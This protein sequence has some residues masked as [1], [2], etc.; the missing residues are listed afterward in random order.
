MY[1]IEGVLTQPRLGLS[2]ASYKQLL[3]ADL[4]IHAG[5]PM[6]I[7]LSLSE[8]EQS[9]LYPAKSLVQLA[10]DIH[11]A[12]GLNHFIHVVGFMSP[13][14]EHNALSD[15]DHLLDNQPP[16]EKMKFLADSYI[17]KSLHS[18][19]IPLST[20]N[21]SVIVGDSFSG[22]TEQ[23]GGLS[24]LVDA[25]RRKLMPLVPGGDDYWLPMVHI[26]HVA[27]FISKLV[28]TEGLTSNTYY[29]LDAKQE[30]PSIRAFIQLM[31]RELQTAQPL[32]KAKV[33]LPL[34][35]TLLGMGAGKVLGIPKESM[36]FLVKSEFPVDSKLEIEQKNGMKSSVVPSTLPFIISDLDY[37][38][39]HLGQNQNGTDDFYQRR[40]A[41][42]I[43]LEKD[44]DEPP[45]IFLHGTFSSADTLLPI[46]RFLSDLNTWFVDLPGFGRTP[47]HHN[48]S[49][50]EGY[51]ESVIAMIAELN[52]PVLLVGHSFGGL[53]AAQVMERLPPMIKQLILM[54]PVL[55]PIQPKYKFR[56]ATSFILK[57]MKP[58]LLEKELLQTKSFLSSS[59]L[60]KDYARSVTRDLKSPRIRKTNAAVM[61]YLTQSKSIQ[62]N[63][64]AWD[65]SKVKILW[66]TLDKDHYIP[67]QFEHL[68]ITNI[69]YGHQFPVESPEL[70][71]EWISGVVRV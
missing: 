53:I 19:G 65:K 59:P 37:R 30:S 10:K 52:R 69:E 46:S 32:G 23:L 36:S 6:N 67:K 48:P 3:A 43:L 18:V 39:N 16:Y 38:L 35:K 31:A 49:V 8:A 22:K 34:L 44:S 21:P 14:H 7:E 24:I 57:Y 63:P 60:L 61:S 11:A 4:I 29:M 26:D 42:L 70:T 64:V 9:F 5:G 12:K 25:V 41:N 56:R 17:R 28:N 13:Y 66:G 50:L 40:R 71:A 47:Y 15:L 33:P 20:V 2:D 55:H 51:V 54:Q 27:S 58:A 45:I 1:P 68:D 62:L